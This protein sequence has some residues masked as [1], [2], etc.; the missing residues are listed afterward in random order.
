MLNKFQRPEES[1][2]FARVLDEYIIKMR[3]S[4]DE[5]SGGTENLQEAKNFICSLIKEQDEKGF[6]A[7][8]PSPRLIQI[9]EFFTG[10]NQLILLQLL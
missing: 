3:E 9:L 8:I 2:Q 7:L 6:W 4:L 5:L 10:M 1:V